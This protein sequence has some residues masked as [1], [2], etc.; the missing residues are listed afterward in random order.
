MIDS[1]E[2]FQRILELK[3]VPFDERYVRVAERT[4]KLFGAHPRLSR[5]LPITLELANLRSPELTLDEIASRLI[6]SGLVDKNKSLNSA[7]R[8][9]DMIFNIEVI[10]VFTN[11]S[12]V[13]SG[14]TKYQ[15]YGRQPDHR[16]YA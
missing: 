11:L 16:K 1:K 3:V 7:R 8:T 12:D 2:I 6:D 13:R 10:Y 9:V 15:L 14:I 4:V 5:L